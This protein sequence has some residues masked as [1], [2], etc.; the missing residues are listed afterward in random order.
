MGYTPGSAAAGG[1]CATSG[2]HGSIAWGGTLGCVECHNAIVNTSAA[3]QALP[4]GSGVTQRRNIV[5]EFAQA[6]SHKRSAATPGTVTSE[7][8]IVCHMEGNATTKNPDATYHGNGYIE[9][10]DP[11]TGAT[12]KEVAWSNSPAGAGSYSSTGNDARFVQFSRNLSSATLESAVTAMQINQCLHCHDADGALSTSAWVTGGS[13]E[14]PF[15]TTIAGAGYTGSGVTANGVTGGVTDIAAAF[16][17][18]NSSYH[19]VLGKQNNA[20]AGYQSASVNRMVSP[21][22]TSAVTKNGTTAVWGF[23][24]TCFDCHAASGASGVQTA[25]VIAHG[26]AITAVTNGQNAVELRGAWYRTGT[27]SATNNVTFCTICH[28][29]YDTSTVTHHNTGSALGSSTNNGMSVYLRYGCF[30]CHSGNSAKPSRPVPGMDVHGFNRLPG[31][32]TDA[33]WPSGTT[34]TWR[35]YAFIRIN[36][37]TPS[38]LSQHRPASGPDLTT[39]TNGQCSSAG[40]TNPCSDGMGTYTPGGKY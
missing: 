30:F 17:T 40:T 34:E 29:G 20:Y 9:L 28:A 22:G 25:T 33:L 10:R 6:S 14:K 13:A 35:P 7:D 19:P 3:T 5:T 15:A 4:G 26:S 24:I 16:S 11:D 32:G 21:W 38:F 12:I 37:V 36:N 2:C 8:C 1:T 18:S 27:P 31:T 23:L 39:Q